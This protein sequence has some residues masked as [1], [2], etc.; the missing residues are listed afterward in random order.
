[1][2]AEHGRKEDARPLLAGKL[3]WKAASYLPAKESWKSCVRNSSLEESERR[4][5]FYFW[6]M[7]ELL[8]K[9]TVQG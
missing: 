8:P 4:K 7:G 1:M 2:N 6:P 5:S 3:S 9:R